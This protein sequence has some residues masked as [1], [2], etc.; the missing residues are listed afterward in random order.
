MP[1]RRRFGSPVRI[2]FDEDLFVGDRL[3]ARRFGWDDPSGRYWLGGSVAFA[4][5]TKPT[6]R[7][8]CSLARL[9]VVYTK[10]SAPK[11]F[12]GFANSVTCAEQTRPR[13]YRNYPRKDIAAPSIGGGG[14][15]APFSEPRKRTI[16]P[17]RL[18]RLRG[19]TGNRIC[20]QFSASSSK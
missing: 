12:Y 18:P 19:R 10:N 7:G 11:S 5:N 3:R 16:S 20:Y 14:G 2:A 6:N 8:K 15:V 1:T 9:D 17:G 4:W 13:R